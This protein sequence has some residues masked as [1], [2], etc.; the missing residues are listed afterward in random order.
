MPGIPSVAAWKPAEAASGEVGLCTA[1]TAADARADD[2][3]VPVDPV[4]GAGLGE[5]G[6]CH[7]WTPPAS[8]TWL[9]GG[10]VVSGLKVLTSAG[11]LLPH[12]VERG[13]G[14]GA[15]GDLQGQGRARVG[16]AVGDHEG[17]LA[18]EPSALRSSSETPS[19]SGSWA[20]SAS[21]CCVCS[22]PRLPWTVWNTL[23]S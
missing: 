14:A 23:V 6:S 21:S 16:L 11:Q 12:R 4:H 19:S 2:R 17:V 5:S 15:V 3:Q 18:A 22:L 20:E 10:S 1:V 9:H 7:P 8:G 13:L